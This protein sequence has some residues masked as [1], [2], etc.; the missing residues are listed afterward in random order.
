MDHILHI[1]DF[2]QFTPLLYLIDFPVSIAT[3]RIPIESW[4][5][6][7]IISIGWCIIMWLI[8]LLIYNRGIKNYEA[9]G[10]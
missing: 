6:N 4:G 8:G 9:Y 7:F 10:S 1:L 2:I 3:G 5:F